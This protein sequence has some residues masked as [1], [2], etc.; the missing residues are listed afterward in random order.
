ISL[1]ASWFPWWPFTLL[2]TVL[3][4]ALPTSRQ[5]LLRCWFLPPLVVPAIGWV[6][7]Y[8]FLSPYSLDELP[9]RPRSALFFV[10][11]FVLVVVALALTVVEDRAWASR[12]KTGLAALLTAVLLGQLP[13][14][15]HVL[16]DD[17][18]ADYSQAA[19]VLTTQLPKDAIVL[20]DTP[21][22]AGWFHQP[23]SA[24]PRYMGGTPYVG[25]VSSMM[26][27]VD[28]VPKRGPVY[29]LMLD[30]E[31]GP[32]TLCDEP[33]RS[34]NENLP[35]WRVATRFDRFTL[36]EPT[37]PLSGRAG[38]L[39]ALTDFAAALGPDL[40]ASETFTAAAL[41]K[42]RGHPERA[43]ALIRQMYSRAG[44][45]AAGR[46]REV[47]DSRGMDPFE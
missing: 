16:V 30:S 8:H 46:I 26:N 2:V 25:Q 18:A 35:G 14:T 34:W 31:C 39:R 38:T 36:Y 42:L 33:P 7:I 43:K 28:K 10:P 41:L 24:K 47:A 19:D 27:Y 29:V 4:F 12:L 20:Y 5:R 17:V 23:F 15:T 45:E 40:G 3:A 6:L 37:R 22:P 44:P 9:Y 11:G 13:A 1:L 21:S 32:S